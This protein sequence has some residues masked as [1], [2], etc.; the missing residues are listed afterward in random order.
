MTLKD[1][2][3]RVM[4]APEGKALA[5][6]KTDDHGWAEKRRC[7]R[8]LGRAGALPVWWDMEYGRWYKDAFIPRMA[9]LSTDDLVA[10]DWEVV[11]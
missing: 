4:A 6:R 5:Y 1:A 11:S 2:M 9:I 10:T 8:A 7:K 3:E